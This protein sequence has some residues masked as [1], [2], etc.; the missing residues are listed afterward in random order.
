MCKV[1]AHNVC[2]LIQAVQALNIHPI[3]ATNNERELD[4]VKPGP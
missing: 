2:V 4:A 3:F 1:L